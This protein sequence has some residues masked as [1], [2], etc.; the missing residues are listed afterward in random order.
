MLRQAIGTSLNVAVVP[1]ASHDAH[2]LEEKITDGLRAHLADRYFNARTDF[3]GTI[4]LG[5][6]MVQGAD[7][8]RTTSI[9]NFYWDGRSGF[10]D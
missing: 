8:L 2:T 4:R 10:L 1:R 9:S 5:E 6:K 7:I 3:N